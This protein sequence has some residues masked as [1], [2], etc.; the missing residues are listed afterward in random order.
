LLA[1]RA[2]LAGLISVAG[3]LGRPACNPAGDEVGRIADI[4]VRWDAGAYPPMA[5]LVLRIAR[6]L[7][8]VPV[9]QVE[10]V[11]GDGARLRSARLDLNDFRH[12]E[13]E[14][15]IASDVLDH[16]LVDVDGVRVVRAADLYLAR[17]G[18]GLVLIGA[19]VGLQTLLRRLGPARWRAR[20]TPERVI[21]WAAIQ[22]F[23]AGRHDLRLVRANRDLHRLRPAELADLLEE[24]GRTQRQQLL[25]A[26]DTDVAADAL[27]EMDPDDVGAVLR[28]AAPDQAAALVAEME[29]D[30][31]ADALRDLDAGERATL[32]A[33]MDT[34]NA[35]ELSALL[36]HGAGSAGSV[37]TT[38]LVLVHEGD[39][40]ELVKS[41]L[42]DEIDHHT[43]ID[44]VLVVDDAG[45]LVD[46]LRLFELFIADPSKR[47]GDLVGEPWPLTVHVHTPLEEVIERFID[48]R[49]SSVVVVDEDG[50][51]V[52]RILADDLVDVL[53]PQRG[54]FH[55]PRILR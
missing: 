14:V 13:G 45:V 37:M 47:L 35:A 30:E 38:H 44:A 43:D 27:E 2:D 33:A 41:R 6:R 24:L 50:K 25:A 49:G 12:R 23:T 9:E 19:D 53:T 34:E 29:P 17:V 46:D 40:V 28:D 32:L 26:L 36:E 42:R 22:P 31:A 21:D 10:E 4:V 39:T 15:A 51:P 7:A 1:S 55:F 52:G 16:Q 18:D 8:F 3:L 48:V 11:S 54:R 5:G 20:P